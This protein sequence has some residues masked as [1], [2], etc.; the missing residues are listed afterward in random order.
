[1]GCA[2][3]EKSEISYVE[4]FQLSTVVGNRPVGFDLPCLD[5]MISH[6]DCLG[7]LDRRCAICQAVC[8]AVV[9]RVHERG[10]LGV[11]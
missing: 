9:V 11:A 3:L 10:I 6:C 8:C 4:N 2:L 5:P 7:T 1:M